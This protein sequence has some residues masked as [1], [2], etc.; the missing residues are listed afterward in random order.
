MTREQQQAWIEQQAPAALA[1][2]RKWGVPASVTLAQAILES[3]DGAG[4]WGGSKL[5]I[6]CCNFFGVKARQGE[7]YEEFRTTEFSN[8]PQ[9]PIPQSGTEKQVVLA[10]FRKY[11]SV[12]E[13]FEAHGRLLGSLARYRPA[14]AVAH[15]PI[16]FAEQLQCCGYST[17]PKYAELL[18]SLIRR[19][20][21][22]RFDSDE[23]L[24]QQATS[25]KPGGQA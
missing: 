7:D 24:K 9:A 18:T 11:A 10:R 1:A 12:E 14:M 6:Q 5:A 16:A 21:L 8:K 22:T 20:D 3:S 19:Y 23:S 15:D 13:S 4:N 2:Q 25:D 17:N